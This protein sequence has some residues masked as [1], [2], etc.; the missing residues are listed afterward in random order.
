MPIQYLH[1]KSTFTQLKKGFGPGAEMQSLFLA[2]VSVQR[3]CPSLLRGRISP[4]SDRG[5]AVCA[6]CT[7]Q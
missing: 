5:T 3:Y 1:L 6:L 4:F 2:L 7:S